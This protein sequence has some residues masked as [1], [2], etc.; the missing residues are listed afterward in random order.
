M[1]VIEYTRWLK[2]NDV[3]EKMETYFKLMAEQF[4]MTL[5]VDFQD[6]EGFWKIQNAKIMTIWLLIY[7]HWYIKTIIPVFSECI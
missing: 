6:L 4:Y 5:N 2:S 3:T 7:L 1:N